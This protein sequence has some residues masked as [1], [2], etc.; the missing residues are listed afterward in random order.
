MAL[1]V[2]Y[3]AGFGT[4]SAA[5]KLKRRGRLAAGAGERMTL[6]WVVLAANRNDRKILIDAVLGMSP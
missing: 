6:R 3:L 1:A 2:T 5:N 4:S